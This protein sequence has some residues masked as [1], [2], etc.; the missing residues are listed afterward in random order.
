MK[1]AALLLAASAAVTAADP[2]DW[3]ITARY[4]VTMDPAR[5][6]IDNGA[7]AV[8]A[9]RIVAIGPRAQLERQY[10]PKQRLDRGN[11]ILAPGL[12]DTHTHAPMSLFR[13]I[14]DDMRLQEWLEK[15][16]FPAEAKNVTAGF[17]KWG[18]LLACLEMSLSGTT[19]YTDMYYFEEVIA[20]ATRQAGLRAVLGQTVI[21]F[22]VPDA[23]TPGEG[24]ARTE[25]F[26]KSYGNDPL[27]TPAP[28]PHA[29]YTT[30]DEVIRQARALANKYG[31]PMLIHL[32]E[33]RRENDDAM[34]S[35]KMSP[36]R[37]LESIGALT[38]RT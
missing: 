22:P 35:R 31:V 5:R 24:L 29:I 13:G 20:E 19:T 1:Y 3:L 18:T 34:A 30:S 4:V 14:A 21:G 7:V 26:L 6:V 37:V 10:S 8:R 28:A 32:S 38:G 15:F 23:K 11:A 36:T 12:I 17:V 27:I 2:V 16:I 33:T 25:R 9:D